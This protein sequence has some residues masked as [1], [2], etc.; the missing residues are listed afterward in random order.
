MHVI[1][2]R[3]RHI[4]VDHFRNLQFWKTSTT[5]G[6]NSTSSRKVNITIKCYLLS[7]VTQGVEKR[8]IQYYLSMGDLIVKK[9]FTDYLLD[10]QS[11]CGD[12]RRDHKRALAALKLLKRLLT[13]RLGEITW[14]FQENCCCFPQIALCC[15]RGTRSGTVSVLSFLP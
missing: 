1:I 6:Q 15:F 5:P 3:G 11:A 9:N 8:V 13:F 7:L 14:D 4:K 2:D 12:F 10:I